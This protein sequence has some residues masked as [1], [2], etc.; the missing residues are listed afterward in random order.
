[1]KSIRLLHTSLLGL[2]GGVLGWTL[3]QSGFKIFDALDTKYFSELNS[4]SLSEFNY[5]G[6]NWTWTGF[7]YAGKSFNN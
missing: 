3:L 4:N 6:V 7:G 5:E 2:L 1:M